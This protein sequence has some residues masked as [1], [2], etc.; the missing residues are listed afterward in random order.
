VRGNGRQYQIQR[1]PGKPHYHLKAIEG[2]AELLPS[3]KD[4]YIELEQGACATND[5]V[6]HKK[7]YIREGVCGAVLLRCKDGR[8][9]RCIKYN[10]GS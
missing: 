8:G 5:P 7:P 9:R 6:M 3:D 1:R 10:K 4:A 2:K